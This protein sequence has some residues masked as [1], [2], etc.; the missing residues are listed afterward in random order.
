M[1]FAAK[2]HKLSVWYNKWKSEQHDFLERWLA[3]LK[4]YGY[5]CTEKKH[6]AMNKSHSS[7][8]SLLVCAALT[9]TFNLHSVA[10]PTD[11]A[12]Q[13][14]TQF[15]KLP[16]SQR[17]AVYWYWISDNISVEGVQHDLEAMKKAGI[18]RAYI[19]NIWQDEVKAGGIKVL[20]PE[21]WEVMHA[22]LKRATEL[23]I[24]IGIFNC[25]GWSQSGG[26][27]IKPEQ[28]MRYLAS[29]EVAVTGNGKAQTIALPSLGN[30][31]QPVCVLAMP[32]AKD[33]ATTFTIDKAA[34]IEANVPLILSKSQTVRSITF[35]TDSYLLVDVILKVKKDGQWHDVK[36]AHLDRTNTALNTGFHPYAPIRI[37]LP[38]VEGDEFMLYCNGGDRDC[39]FT[40][41]LSDCPVVERSEEKTLAKMFQTP[42]PMWDEYMWATQPEPQGT[43]T[44]SQPEDVIDLTGCLQAD[45][46]LVWNAPKGDWTVIST[47]MVPTGVTNAPASAEATGYEVDKMSRKHVAA[48]FDAFLGELMRRIPEADR[49]CFRIV[50]EDSYETGGQNWTDDMEESFRATYGYDPRPFIPA[51]YGHV[52]GSQDQSERFLWDLRRLIAD[53][54]A[55]D[56]VGGLRDVSHQHGLTTWL[57]C[58]G[59]WGFPSEFLMYGGQSDEVAGEF[60]SEGSLGDIENRAASSCAH[61]YGKQKVWAE[62]CTAGGPNFSRYPATMKE[63]TDR[64]FCEGINATLLHLFIQQPDDATFPGISAPF[65][66]DF[67]RKNT[68][69]SQMDLFTDY[70]RRCNLMLQ[71]GQYVAD[72]AYYIGEDAPKMTG[73]CDPALPRG[74]SFDYLNAEVLLQSTVSDGRLTL[75]SG[76]QYA[77][78]VLPKQN[79]MRPAVM[80]KIAELAHEGLNIVGPQ[81]TQSPSMKDY[82]NADQK[83]QAL[84]GT[85]WNNDALKGNVW[86]D[87]T[88][89]STILDKKHVRP[90]LVTANDVPVAY[91]H[92]HLNDC[93]IYFVSNQSTQT[94]RFEALFR[95]GNGTPELWH[96][97]TGEQRVL[98]Q[99]EAS[100][101]GVSVPLLLEPDESVF[102]VFHGTDEIAQQ[103]ANFPEEEVA[104]T[105]KGAWTVAFDAAQRGP[106]TPQAFVDLTSW[107]ES[108]DDAI[109]YYSGTAT[110][111]NTLKLKRKPKGCIYLDL[112]RVMVMARVYVNGQYAG[113]AWAYP[114]RV[115][116]SQLLRKGKNDIRIEV[117]NNWQNRL[118][119]DQQLPEDQ[120]PTWTSVNPWH[121]DSPLQESGLLGPVRL[122]TY[123]TE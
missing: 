26:P 48:H 105:L 61:I 117:V 45:G 47:A 91:I 54:I 5:F 35:C 37:S 81:P 104:A 90:D 27:W 113:G 14:R 55:Y 80:E 79:T 58:Y 116:V 86:A 52:I 50:V 36:F 10:A 21:W 34:G 22:A 115:E 68:W 87:G 59:H 84:A 67:Q 38:D 1:F 100:D 123:G 96:P 13:L 93:D 32:A 18:T 62:S 4:D 39:H 109:R 25:P 95:D 19:G 3:R 2:I 122:L 30:E 44:V 112:G 78:L 8:A 64:F 28:S 49:K 7:L 73:V 46:R 33:N 111:T 23:D 51:L 69:F 97:V 17:V 41:T 83:V 121:A 89:L 114:Y 94:Q 63:R 16:D 53:R 12:D 42:L 88:P 65:G 106:A 99:Y 85:V 57:E 74:Y 108:K 76:M 66:N 60:W 77:V 70:L 15:V 29:S 56:Y 40:A 82:P 24:E 119:G 11:N 43:V 98:S 92:R 72:V 102:I 110:Y 107:T 101:K 120:R 20:T 75:P 6:N 118:I 31:S 103:P 9:A 71:Q